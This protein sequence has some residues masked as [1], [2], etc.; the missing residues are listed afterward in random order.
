M[1]SLKPCG[2]STG[3]SK[4]DTSGR[5]RLIEAAT[6]EFASRG[7]EGARV[8]V[9]ARQAGL[10]KQLIYHYFG[11]KEA[12]HRE[13]M[14][15]AYADFRGDLDALQTRTARLEPEA[16]LRAF[17]AHLYPPGGRD[18]SFQRLLIDENV[19]GAP[20]VVSIPEIP[21]IYQR[22]LVIL[23][24]ILDKGRQA[25]VFVPIPDVREFYVSL[26]GII[27][28]RRSNAATLSHSVGLAL[29]TD[30]GGVASHNAAVEFIMLALKKRIG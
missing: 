12:L 25:G 11:S 27:G 16:A 20:S 22:I 24:S 21:V 9:I 2:T 7:F 30:E 26:I 5:E 28:V 4:D 10:N 15:R 17:I 14:A 3:H 18:F 6:R 23:S 13:V 8:N 19:R 1:P 29:Q